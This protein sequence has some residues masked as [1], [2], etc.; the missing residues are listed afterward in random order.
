MTTANNIS[1]QFGH[2]GQ[3]FDAGD[4]NISDIAYEAADHLW[5]Y[6]STTVYVFGDDSM[7]L[8]TDNC[9]DIVTSIAG[10]TSDAAQQAADNDINATHSLIDSNDETVALV[11]GGNIITLQGDRY[12][13]RR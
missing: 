9:W 12:T 10:L 5:T 8:V 7:L 1:A 13:W 3:Q 11:D 4:I 6:G 2:D